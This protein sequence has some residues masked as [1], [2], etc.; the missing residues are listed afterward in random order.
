MGCLIFAVLILWLLFGGG[1]QVSAWLVPGLPPSI[2]ALL[3]VA[4]VLLVA[5]LSLPATRCLVQ[6][7][8]VGTARSLF[9][10]GRAS[11]QVSLAACRVIWTSG[12]AAWRRLWAER[13]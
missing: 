12:R 2:G 3:L 9:V 8:I 6:A 4:S 10:V 1:Q 13:T 7:V 11:L 5:G